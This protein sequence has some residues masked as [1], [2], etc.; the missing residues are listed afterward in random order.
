M[1]THKENREK[2]LKCEFCG[3]AFYNNNGLSIHRRIHVGPRIPCSICSKEYYRQSDLD[4]HMVSHSATRV[5]GD[6][7]F[8]V[9]IQQICEVSNF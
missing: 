3:K 4:K 1:Y 6:L 9:S 2:N 5:D 8:R 7:K